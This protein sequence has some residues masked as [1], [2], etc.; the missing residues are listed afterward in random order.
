MPADT[1]LVA[2]PTRW[3]NPFKI[4]QTVTGAGRTYRCTTAEDVVQAFAAIP[5]SAA[6]HTEI[7]QALGGKNLACWCGLDAPCHADVLLE[8][9][10]R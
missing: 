4:G 1:I 6:D 9:A 2:R 5:R 8:I 3:G 7:A 10:N